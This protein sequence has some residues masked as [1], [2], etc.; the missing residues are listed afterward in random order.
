VHLKVLALNI[1]RYV[2]H[3]AQA[4]ATTADPAPT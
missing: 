4:A 1:S 3:L 2:G